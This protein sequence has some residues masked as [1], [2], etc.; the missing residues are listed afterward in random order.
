MDF[1]P[2]KKTISSCAVR[3]LSIVVLMF[4]SLFRMG[5]GYFR[6]STL[7]VLLSEPDVERHDK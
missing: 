4:F 2:V 7:V 6:I 5:I 3:G 1:Q